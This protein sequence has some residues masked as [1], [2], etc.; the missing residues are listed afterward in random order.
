LQGVLGIN[1]RAEHPVAVRLQLGTVLTDQALEGARVV[2]P[3]RLEIGGV[4]GRFGRGVHWLRE[5]RPV[6]RAES[7]RP[8]IDPRK[9]RD[10][11]F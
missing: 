10:L 4:A 7:I 3:S 2:P 1:R 9:G 5:L 11:H 8:A 6:D